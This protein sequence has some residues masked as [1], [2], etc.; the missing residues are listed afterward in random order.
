RHDTRLGDEGCD[1]FRRRC[2]RRHVP[3][4]GLAGRRFALRLDG[5]AGHEG[6]QIFRDNMWRDPLPRSMRPAETRSAE[7]ERQ[8]LIGALSATGCVSAFAWTG[9]G[10]SSSRNLSSMPS[11][12][13]FAS[14][15]PVSRMSLCWNA[16][17]MIVMPDF[18]QISLLGMTP[19]S[20]LNTGSFER[21]DNILNLP[22]VMNGTRRLSSVTTL[23]I[24]S[25]YSLAKYSATSAPMECPTMVK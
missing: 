23:A 20:V 18:L 17:W 9:A 14:S 10:V 8:F 13:A 21:N 5:F 12:E 22:S 19:G 4:R 3:G 7:T 11:I 2:Q 1:V 6:S 24:F 25:G 16:V 15:G